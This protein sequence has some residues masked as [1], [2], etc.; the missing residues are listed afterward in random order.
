MTLIIVFTNMVIEK[1]WQPFFQIKVFC[2]RLFFDDFNKF[3]KLNP[4]KE[5]KKKREDIG[6][7]DKASAVHDDFLGIYF[8]EYYELSS[9]K[10]KETIKIFLKDM[11]IW[12]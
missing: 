4:Q 6:Q 9:D 10:R 2:S 7:Y 1:I 3:N 8:Y 5:R 11:V 12:L